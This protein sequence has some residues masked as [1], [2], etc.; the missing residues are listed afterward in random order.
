MEGDVAEPTGCRTIA[1]ARD[2]REGD[3][4]DVRT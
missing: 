3:E 2:Q 4:E 1:A